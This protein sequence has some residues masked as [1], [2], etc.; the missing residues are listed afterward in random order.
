MKFGK[1]ADSQAA[2]TD[3]DTWRQISIRSAKDTATTG[4]RVIRPDIEE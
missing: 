4:T 3:M 1:F 2:A